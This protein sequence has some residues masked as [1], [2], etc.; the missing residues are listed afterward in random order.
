MNKNF[1][2]LLTF[3]IYRRLQPFDFKLYKNISSGDS[4]KFKIGYIDS[5]DLFPS[6]KGNYFIK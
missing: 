3:D 4:K 2:S 1:F 5:L 6:T